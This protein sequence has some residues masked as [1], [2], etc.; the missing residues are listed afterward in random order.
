MKYNQNKKYIN[1]YLVFNFILLFVFTFGIV[2]LQK[3]EVNNIKETTLSKEEYLKQEKINKHNLN[4]QT[5][6]PTLGFANLVAD[7]IHLQFLQYFGDSKARETIGYSL[8]PDYFEAVV[9]RDPRFIRAYFVLSP[10]TSIFA[11]RPKKA[12]DLTAKGLKS[13]TPDLHS[14]A[15]YLWIYKGT[16]EMLFLG[17]TK[18][19]RES[20]KMAAIWAEKSDR[21]NAKQSA[22]NALQTAEF[23]EQNSGSIIAQIGAWTMVLNSS[24]GNITRQKAMKEIE[25]LGGQIIV[26]PDGSVKIKVPENAT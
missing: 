13:V 7:W 9:E 2:A 17:D 4:I 24:S 6:I 26:K 1:N 12:I 25:N 21:P 19:A 18:S 22:K 15:Y 3:S 10:A 16:D 11:G 23:L 5:Q 14:D 8:S 20:Y